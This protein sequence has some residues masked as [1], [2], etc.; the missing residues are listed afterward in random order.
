MDN[1]TPQMLRRYRIGFAIIA[2]AGLAVPLV[3]MQF[4]R[5]EVDWAF[6]DFLVFGALL[7]G[8]GVAIEL[9]LRFAP[10]RTLRAAVIG[11]ALAGF[12]FVWAMLAVA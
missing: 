11:V 12:V 1:A 2:L 4:S 5:D 7:A 3:A 10:S 9:A 8:L 6:G